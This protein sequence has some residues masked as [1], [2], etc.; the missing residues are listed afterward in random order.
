SSHRAPT[1][2]G[3]GIAVVAATL[4]VAWAAIALS[5]PPLQN[6]G[7]RMLAL[8]AMTALLA[9]VGAVDD[10]RTLPAAARFAL[11]CLAV[12]VVLA[13][14]PHDFRVLPQAPWWI[15]RAALLLVG[16]WFVNLVNF[17]DGID[18]MTVA[19]VVP[20]TGALVVLGL[21]GTIALVPSVIAAAL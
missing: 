5:S 15:E 4:V 16:V 7:G 9:A 13:T 3:G 20:V 21:S 11:Q 2:Q 12:I 8:A 17:M 19:E 1:P 14:L 6:D 18:W 10:V